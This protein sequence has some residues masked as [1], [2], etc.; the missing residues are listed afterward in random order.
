MITVIPNHILR[1]N[2]GA[3]AAGRQADWVLLALDRPNLVPTRLDNL[4]ENLIWAADG[5]EVDTVVARGRVLKQGG[6][7]QPFLDGTKAEEVMAA[8]QTLSERFAAHMETAP[9]LQGT[10]V[11]GR[12]E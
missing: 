7:V 6:K 9:A 2:Q 4:T 10:G 8:V 3:L 11:H 12:S 5:G 1:L